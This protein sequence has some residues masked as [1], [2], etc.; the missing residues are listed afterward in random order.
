MSPDLL[1]KVTGILG[2]YILDDIFKYLFQQ[3]QGVPKRGSVRR[4]TISSNEKVSENIPSFK[5]N[6]FSVVDTGNVN[7][8]KY[9]V[10]LYS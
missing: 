7:T 5:I 9:F 3:I 10:W 8:V 1:S 2:F 4:L 6:F